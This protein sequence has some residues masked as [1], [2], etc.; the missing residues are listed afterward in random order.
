MR[1]TTQDIRETTPDMDAV[2]AAWGEYRDAL[3]ADADS[4]REATAGRL[5]AA[6]VALRAAID[7]AGK[8]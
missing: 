1:E 4:Y 2:C 6:R 5:E 8:E 7:A 3:R